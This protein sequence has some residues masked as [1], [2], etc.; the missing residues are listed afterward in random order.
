[1]LTLTGGDEALHDLR[2]QEV[3]SNLA[4]GVVYRID[5]ALGEGGMSV[6]LFALRVAPEGQTP[7]VLKML[8]PSFV[9]DAGPTAAM[10][11]QKE[12][13]ALGRLNERVPP[14][15]FVVRLIDTGALRVRQQGRDLE[16]PWLAVEYVHGGA[17]G[18][19]LTERVVYAIRSTGCAF[20]PSRAAHAVQCL[21]KGMQA[22]HDVGVIHR[23]VKPDNILCCGFGD[24]E[25]FKVADFGLAR[26]AGVAATF[27]GLIVGTPGY[28]APELL[29]LD[30]SRIGPWTDIF[31]C[32][33]VTFFLL[34][35]EDYFLGELVSELLARA[36][37]PGRRSLLGCPSLSPE[38]A[39][40]PE[41]CRAIDAALAR[42]T[43]PKAADRPGTAVELAALLTPALRADSRRARPQP[44]LV[45]SITGEESTRLAGWSWLVR[46]HPGTDRVVRHAAWDADGTCLAATSSGLAFWS[47][48][49]W[50]EAPRHAL[51]DVQ[52]LRFVH[53]VGP[54]QWLVG[55]DGGVLAVYSA[56]GVRERISVPDPAVDYDRFD[57]DLDDL[58]VLC[59]AARG[60]P[61]ALHTLVSRRW[62]KP[63]ALEGVA[64]IT[65]LA[66]VDDDKWLVA[67]RSSQGGAYAALYTPLAW[68]LERID[69][70]PVRALLACASHVDRR[71]GLA[72]GAEG[73]VV[74]RDRGT[75]SQE[76]VGPAHDLSSAAVDVAGRGWAASAGRI[77]LRR[78]ARKSEPWGCVWEDD[79][80]T[81]PMVSLFADVGVVLG[82]T[83]D[84]GIVEGRIAMLELADTTENPAFRG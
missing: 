22:V 42:A 14:T 73:A 71:V 65:S 34:T 38:L 56:D 27:G 12:A 57:G 44:S 1:M 15:P 23:D 75:V 13:V 69:V 25:V 7:V 62:L 66:R 35:G 64:A 40:R 18:T 36:R 45:E 58:A 2:G 28:A 33:G 83:A 68:D 72:V 46:W 8:K 77:W 24:S 55:G 50:L 16:L 67:G 82:M 30:A 37:E 53:R 52:Q 76:S 10:T 59:G 4:R 70:P 3:P 51:P 43:S 39:A 41:A 17:E 47:G 84:A 21:A 6:A 61:P 26:P 48:T 20:D 32:A 49:E 81:A 79:T 80:W 11:V 74:W 78:G 5:K 19:T 60:G 63:M 9:R 31:A 29:S 54:A